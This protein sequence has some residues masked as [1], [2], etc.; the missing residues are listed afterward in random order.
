MPMGK[1]FDYSINFDKTDFRKH[2]ELYRVGKGEQGVLL[3]EPYKS[4]ILPHWRFKNPDIARES[5]EK[6]Y[7]MFLNYLEQ[8]DF[9]GADMARKYLQMGYT[10]ARRYANHK[11]GK[12]YKGPVPDDKKGQ[13]GAH[14]REQLPL[15]QDPVK[16]AAAEIFYEKWQLAKQNEDY[17]ELKEKFIAKYSS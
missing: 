16:A 14:G 4:E 5:S 7:E 10:R 9:V 12:K 13:S 6:I 3:V 1:E 8:Q 15:D 17:Q 11:S 2:P